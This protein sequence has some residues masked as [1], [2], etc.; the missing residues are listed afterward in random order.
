MFVDV[1]KLIDFHSSNEK[2]TYYFFIAFICV[3][4][5]TACHSIHVEVI[6]QFSRDNSFLPRRESWKLNS[7]FRIGGKGLYPLSPGA[8]PRPHCTPQWGVYRW[9]LIIVL[10]FHPSGR[11]EWRLDG[12]FRDIS[13]KTSW[14][15]V[16]DRNFDTLPNIFRPQFA[17]QEDKDSISLKHSP[18]LWA[19]RAQWQ[20]PNPRVY[21]WQ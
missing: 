10:I 20:F 5:G 14:P 8:R 12:A 1:Y 13:P 17:Y 19:S 7:G 3:C 11:H 2:N 15:A 21:W 18:L 4:L 9:P 6:G 16:N